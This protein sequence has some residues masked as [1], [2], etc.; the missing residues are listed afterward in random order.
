VVEGIW[1]VQRGR[2]MYRGI[3]R[4]EWKKGFGRYRGEDGNTRVLGTPEWRK[5]FGRYR[6][7]EGSTDVLGRPDWKKEFGSY[8]GGD[9]DYRGIRE[10]GVEEGIWKL[11]RV[12]WGLQGYWGDRSGRRNLEVTEGEMGTTGVLGRPE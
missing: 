2:G 6:G 11:Q 8:R 9:G 1:K 7:G 3:G 10:T 5:E 4:P 12:R